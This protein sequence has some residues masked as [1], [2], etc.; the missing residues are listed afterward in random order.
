M[1]LGEFIA[2]LGTDPFWVLVFFAMMPVAALLGHVMGRGEGNEAPWNYYYSALIYL[3]CIPGIFAIAL[4]IY[5]FLFEKR[6]ILQTDMYTQILPILTMAVTLAIMRRNVNFNHIPGFGKLS[7]LF[8]V[9]MAAFLVMW[10]LDK[11]KIFVFSY[12]PFHYLIFIFL[13]IL[14]VVMLGWRKLTSA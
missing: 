7:G 9:I 1:T 11:L 4:S 14:F 8:I 10:L 13:G 2:N 12:M 3:V 6:P 5:L